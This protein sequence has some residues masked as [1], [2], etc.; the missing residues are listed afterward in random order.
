MPTFVY[1]LVEM[2]N[3]LVSI[4]TP[5]YNAE[6]YVGLTIE[7][8]LKQTYT[9][10][11]MLIINDGSSDRSEEIIKQYV[12]RD[13]RIKLFTQKNAGSAAARNNGIRRAQ[14]R[15]ICLLDADDMWDCDFLEMQLQL[16]ERKNAQLVYSSFRRVDAE[17]KECLRPFLVPKTISYTDMLKTNSIGCLTGIYDRRK[18]GKFFLH[19]ELGS[20]RDDYVYWLEILK[21]VGFAHGN[22]QVLASYRISSTSQTHDKRKMIKHQFNVY[23]NIIKLNLIKSLYYLACWAWYGYKK[24]KE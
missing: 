6:R 19:E 24:Y 21:K 18:Y 23:R 5:V 8:V 14:G 9:E 16:M 17:G 3:R 4:I 10:W 2:Q 11:E 1:K 15:Y 22:Q 20:L 12:E 7:S 13:S